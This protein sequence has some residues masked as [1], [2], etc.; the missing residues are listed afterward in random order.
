MSKPKLE[1]TVYSVPGSRMATLLY[2]LDK[3]NS[4]SSDDVDQLRYVTTKIQHCL[5]D[6]EKVR[7]EVMSKTTNGLEILLATLESSKDSQI[8]LNVTYSL[9]DLLQ[10]PK[11][12]QSMVSR[13]ATQ[14]LLTALS[15]AS[16]QQPVCEEL[17]A[18]LH[19]VLAKVSPK[20]RKFGVKARLSGALP[21]TMAIVR[22]NTGNL[23]L[24]QPMVQVLKIYCTNSVNSSHL[25]KAGAVSC[26]LKIVSL[27]GKRYH[28]VLRNS[29][30]TLCLLVKSKSNSAR[31]IG[32]GG[33]PILV[34][35]FCEWQKV[36]VRN[37]HISVRK[38]I[39]NVIK[40][41]TTLKSGKK[42]FADSDGIKLLYNAAQDMTTSTNKDIESL[43]NIIC[44]ILRKCFPR[45][46]LPLPSILSCIHFTLPMIPEGHPLLQIFSGDDGIDESDDQDDDV[47]SGD[48]NKEEEK[49]KVEGGEGGEGD[50]STPTER[51]HRTPEDLAMYRDFFPELSDFEEVMKESEEPEPEDGVQQGAD[52][53]I[54]IPTARSDPLRGSS[55]AGNRHP[56]QPQPNLRENRFSLPNLS[57]YGSMVASYHTGSDDGNLD[58]KQSRL[59]SSRQGAPAATATT[60]T[61]SWFPV[62][63]H[64][65]TTSVGHFNIGGCANSGAEPSSLRTNTPRVTAKQSRSF[66]NLRRN[67]SPPKEPKGLKYTSPERHLTTHALWG[68]GDEHPT[69]SIDFV[70][71][72]MTI[73]RMTLRSPE[74]VQDD[75]LLAEPISWD[76]VKP[77]MYGDLLA[78]TKRVLPFRRIAHPEI[79]GH[80][81]SPV[82]E[83]FYDRPSSVQRALQ[84]EDIDRIIHPQKVMERIVYDLDE[85][86]KTGAMTFTPSNKSLY[87]SKS[88]AEGESSPLV[89]NSLFESGNLRKA[90]QVRKYEYDL[91]A[92][93]D[94][95][96]N[97]YHQW[98]YFE[99]SNIKAGVRYRFN[100]INCEK[101]NSQFNSGMQPV[102]Y[103]MREAML[104]RP[105]WERAG[106]EVAYYKNNY[107]RSLVATGGQ[108]G[109]TYFTLAYT[110]TFQHDN[111]ICY[112]AY[113]Y[114]YTYTTLQV[115]L[116]KLEASLG[117]FSKIYLRRQTLCHSLGGNEC[118]VLTITANPTSLDK[119]GVTQFRNRRYIFLSARVHPAESNSS[120]IMKG[121]LKFL[122]ST[123]PTAQALRETFIFK[124]VPMLN[125]DGVINGSHR[126]SLSGEDLNRRWLLPNKEL[127][128]TIYHTKGLLQY[129]TLIN[130]SPLVYCDYH[131]HSRKK[132]V[133]MFGNSAAQSYAPEDLQNFGIPSGVS[134]AK[135]EDTSY[136]QLPRILNNLAPAFSLSTCSFTIDKDKDSAA[137]VVVWRE[138]GVARSYTMESTYCGFD[139]GKYKGLQVSTSMLEEMGQHFCEGLHKLA[140]R[141]EASASSRRHV[142]N[143]AAGATSA[144]GGSLGGPSGFPQAE[145]M[146]DEDTDELLEMEH[147]A[148]PERKRS[149]IMTDLKEELTPSENDIEDGEEEEE[150]D[151][152]DEEEEEDAD[153]DAF[154]LDEE[155]IPKM[156][157]GDVGEA[158][159][160][161]VELEPS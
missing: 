25:G 153:E 139:Q 131:G 58:G 116:C 158:A 103:S 57:K 134:G 20:D 3:L 54:H 154:G 2:S 36:D 141:L 47:S 81:P 56:S 96:S 49:P 33:M 66:H 114:P 18:G 59:S 152:L 62:E 92:C 17:M 94:I 14:V 40:N 143:H 73:S 87:N 130:R 160:N 13:G 98:F 53:F 68:I 61:N 121:T 132:N 128:P 24:I 76:E 129:L 123:H 91:I 133:F 37:R 89:F 35:A 11:R 135:V 100:M 126:C 97:H 27:C 138:M 113:H 29:L 39:L 107:N 122:V 67:H 74:V 84:L 90:I 156:T 85:L 75:A 21:I 15:T 71:S 51:Q 72:S 82:V 137:R 110:L 93:T 112:I 159:V 60:K 38:G 8:S 83:E 23:D 105:R 104:G 117:E 41:I 157:Q 99:V 19:Q 63:N 79:H 147:E 16:K 140:K 43:V 142:Y 55:R 150:D 5:K 10:S 9:L 12:A 161:D 111:D 7:K 45:N 118:P 102:V 31:A 124:I 109:K 149:H 80:F 26:M 136:K 95:N 50:K 32:Q 127:H 4:S 151:E 148:V 77:D 30:E 115:H 86:M 70:R 120:F 144:E 69:E 48:E 125:P 119:E 1:K 64:D 145:N 6:H 42:A 46:R 34:Q 106:S 78:K 44:I 88:G 146:D 52:N 155:A 108:K 65:S 28:P 22:V 101:V